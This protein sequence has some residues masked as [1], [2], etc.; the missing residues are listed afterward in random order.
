MLCDCSEH[1]IWLHPLRLRRQVNGHRRKYMR[2]PMRISRPSDPMEYSPWQRQASILPPS[3][4]PPCIAA[5][6]SGAP[7]FWSTLPLLHRYCQSLGESRDPLSEIRSPPICCQDRIGNCRGLQGGWPPIPGT[8]PPA[9]KRVPACT[10]P[11]P[12]QSAP[13][14]CSCFRGCGASPPHP[15]Y[16]SVLD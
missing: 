11:S 7:P 15:I 2:S 5:H 6:R 16:L 12:S 1:R 3:R 9:P 8:P 13:G 4:S 10:S 14:P